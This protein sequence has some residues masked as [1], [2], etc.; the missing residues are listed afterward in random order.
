MQDLL[1]MIAGLKRPRLLVQAARIGVE[2][3]DREI[4]LPRLLAVAAAP[5]CGDAII[6]LLAREAEM[7]GRRHG[8]DGLYSVGRQIDLVTALMGEARMLRALQASAARAAAT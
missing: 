5:R 2:D 3:Y 6:A 8:N 7:E 4:R 1:G